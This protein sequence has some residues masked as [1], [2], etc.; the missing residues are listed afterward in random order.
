MSNVNVYSYDQIK[1]GEV[2]SF[3]RTITKNDVLT[4]SSLTGDINP[5]H[6]D[7]EF[8]KKSKF[9][10]NI[11]HG[12]LISSL[13]SRLVGVHCP[14]E[15]CLYL[16]QSCQFKQP[17]F[18]DETVEVIGTVVQKTDALRMLKMKM[19]VIR[20]NDIIVTGEAQVQLID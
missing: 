4:F 19:E 13:F 16:S 3:T 15:K 2:H 12:M 20:E 10:K 6:I 17:L 18:Y 1:V 9:G 14:G 7:E 11:V 8:G 5:L